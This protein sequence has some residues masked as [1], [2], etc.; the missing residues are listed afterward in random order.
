MFFSIQNVAIFIVDISTLFAMYKHRKQEEIRYAAV[1][2]TSLLT[3]TLYDLHQYHH[4]CDDQENVDESTHG[5]CGNEAKQPQDNQDNCNC[6]EH[7]RT[8]SV[9]AESNR[10]PAV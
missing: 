10:S 2:V 9:N 1:S 5:V 8:S 4:D 6:S 7:F 3:S